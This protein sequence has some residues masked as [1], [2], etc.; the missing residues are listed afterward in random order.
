VSLP[1]AARFEM[2]GLVNT[3]A[4]KIWIASLVRDFVNLK[5]LAAKLEHLRHE[6]HAVELSVL[7]ESPQNLFPAPDLYP[8]AYQQFASPRFHLL[9]PSAHAYAR[10]SSTPT[11]RG[12]TSILTPSS[13]VARLRLT[14]SDNLTIA[15]E[16]RESSLTVK[17]A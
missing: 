13:S 15:L 9:T 2:D 3:A 7:I 12:H 1:V 4:A 8:I 5:T 17:T 16:L 6:R 11:D 10:G 14:G